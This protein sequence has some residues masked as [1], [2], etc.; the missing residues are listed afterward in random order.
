MSTTIKVGLGVEQAMPCPGTWASG[1]LL[2]QS[3]RTQILLSAFLLQP[4]VFLHN[5]Y[6]PHPDCVHSVHKIDDDINSQE[7]H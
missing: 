7:Q 4:G 3:C 6:P 2:G 5:Q 1:E